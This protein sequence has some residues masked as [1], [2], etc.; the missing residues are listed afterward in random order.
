VQSFKIETLEIEN[1]LAAY[2]VC[3]R[4][5]IADEE[6]VLAAK[7]F[8]KPP[9]RIEF[10]AKIGSICFYN[11]S[12]STSVASVVHAVKTLSGPIILIAGGQDKG[13]SYQSWNRDFQGKVRHVFAI[14]DCAE[15]LKKELTL[16]V[17]IQRSLEEAVKGAYKIAKEN[18]S[19][20]LS[21]GCSSFD[22]F[23]NYE[24]RGE[25]FKRIVGSL[26]KGELKK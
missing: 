10:V 17:E 26:E 16:T 1:L 22:M 21:P 20:L 14:G 7:S 9:H 3:Q 8:K 23:K 13:L 25:E 5:K 6:F 18:E 24:H 19:I 4:W 15:K 12:K 11:D 2:A